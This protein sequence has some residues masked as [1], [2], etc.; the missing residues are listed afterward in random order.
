MTLVTQHR[1]ADQGPVAG[2]AADRIV[3]AQ[4]RLLV[5]ELLAKVTV[6]PRS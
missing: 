5:D 4:A 6:A 1:S 3:A 2:E